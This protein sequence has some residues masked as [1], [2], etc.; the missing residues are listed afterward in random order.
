MMQ[1]NQ[2]AKNVAEGDTGKDSK[3]SGLGGRDE[4]AVL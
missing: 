1:M 4:K 2:R 3:S